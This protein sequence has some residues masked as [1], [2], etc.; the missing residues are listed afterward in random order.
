MPP[1]L[2]QAKRPKRS[3]PRL[4]VELLPNISIG[5][6]CRWKVFPDNW[7]SQHKLEALFRLSM[8]EKP[9]H[10]PQKH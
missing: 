8:G 10:F 5:D 9:N 4:I 3:E 7:Y 6:L 2:Q 1:Q